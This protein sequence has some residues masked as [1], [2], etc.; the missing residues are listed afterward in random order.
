MHDIMLACIVLDSMTIEDE[1]HL[2]HYDHGYL[3]EDGWVSPAPPAPVDHDIVVPIGQVLREVEV[4]DIHY[5]LK[6]D[7][8]E[9]IWS[10]LG[11]L[12]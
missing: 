3:F 2:H 12:K 5:E 10:V 8:I 6:N 1:L 7:L 9:H 4:A 11:G